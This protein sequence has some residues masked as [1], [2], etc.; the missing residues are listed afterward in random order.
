MKLRRH[1]LPDGIRFLWF[2]ADNNF[3]DHFIV[4]T[5]VFIVLVSFLFMIF[6]CNYYKITTKVNNQS[7]DFANTVKD[8]IYK[9]KKYPRDLYPDEKLMKMLF[10]ERD[11]YVFD[12]IGRWHLNF[13]ELVGD[14]LLG[15]AEFKP[16]PEGDKNK[17]PETRKNKRY[18][19]GT[20]A[21][22]IK[23]IN[24]YV[25]RLNVN[26][27]GLA[28]IPVS[29]INSCEIY[30]HNK[31]KTAG[32]TIGTFF[33][34]VGVAFTIMLIVILLTSCPFVYA[35]DGNSWQFI[36]EIYGGAV[37]PCLE[38]HDYLLMPNYH[39]GPGSLYRVKVANMLEEIQYINKADMLVLTHD[40][41][42]YP[43]IDKYGTIQTISN[44]IQPYSAID[45]K[46]NDF[47]GK[48]ISK[49][50]IT[51]NFDEELDTSG[52]GT[53]LNSL[54]LT[55]KSSTNPETAKLYLNGKN[56]LWGDYMIRQFFNLFGSRYQKF[57]D[58]QGDKPADF[59]LEWMQQQGLLMQVFVLKNGEWKP[60]DYFNMVGAVG[61]RDMVLPLN[62]ENA[63][64]V[65][66]ADSTTGYTLRLKLVSGYMF[67]DI[68]YAAIDLSDNAEVGMIWLSP[69]NAI[70]QSDNSVLNLLSSDDDRY[71][72]Q[73]VTGDEVNLD[74]TLP[75]SI[76]PSFTLY[77]HSKGYYQQAGKHIN[78]PDISFLETFRHPGRLSLWSSQKYLE[79]KS[80][81]QARLGNKSLH[82]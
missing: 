37:Y 50:K 15:K 74:F 33:I 30:K 31:G 64:S 49:D 40:S 19:N 6:G 36:G 23:R 75:D 26:D 43:L 69:D 27:T 62:L 63:W 73:N 52:T 66:G 70:D 14:T 77:L 22:I 58:K 46:G 57:V 81:Y 29:S 20:E 2:K 65:E 68:D 8:D 13:P 72:V 51:Y 56:D 59:H 67:W 1:L 32:I 55:F 25:D 16:I 4:P 7:G 82:E 38:R 41:L 79:L 3:A 80:S 35:F 45:S 76:M 48:V 53:N 47:S 9:E 39:Y 21:D 34:V 60:A 42:V 11:I 17:L 18:H 78:E 71:L 24:F 61:S 28:Y 54:E 44:P 5:A 10:I 12:S